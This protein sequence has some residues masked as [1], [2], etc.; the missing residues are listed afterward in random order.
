MI[1]SE[2]YT[3]QNHFSVLT[4]LAE[5]VELSPVDSVSTP[6]FGRQTGISENMALRLPFIALVRPKS[7]RVELVSDHGYVY[8]VVL[9][10]ITFLAEEVAD[11]L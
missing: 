5:L 8:I 7:L 11:L 4:M 10:C 6:P 9:T 3:F 1:P 2:F